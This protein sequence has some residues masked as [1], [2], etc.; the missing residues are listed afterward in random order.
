VIEAIGLPSNIEWGGLV[1][2]ENVSIRSFMQQQGNQNCVAV[3]TGPMQ[4]SISAL[5]GIS[6][7][8]T[9]EGGGP[10]QAD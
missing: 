2:V 10:C 5:W 8:R 4:K 3:L 1:L 9:E 7:R 6:E